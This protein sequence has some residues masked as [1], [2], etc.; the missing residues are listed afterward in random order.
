MKKL[1]SINAFSLKYSE[2]F[3]KNNPE[4]GYD[5]HDLQI[6]LLLVFLDWSDEIHRNI[7]REKEDGKISRF[8]PEEPNCTTERIVC[9]FLRNPRIAS[10]WISY[11][12]DEWSKALPQK[13]EL[14]KGRSALDVLDNQEKIILSAS[15]EPNQ[16][17]RDER[18]IYRLKADL[19][20]GE[21][22]LK[23]ENF[24]SDKKAP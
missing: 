20:Q 4:C 5:S 18:T 8:T 12:E 2:R 16:K 22:G 10:K 11:I 24:L 15:E 3:L 6:L 9:L 13:K 17:K 19:E 21:E 7:L 1:H 14:M 23:P